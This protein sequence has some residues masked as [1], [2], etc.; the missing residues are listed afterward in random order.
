MIRLRKIDVMKMLGVKAH[1]FQQLLDDG[2]VDPPIEKKGR[3][4]YYTPAHVTRAR[5]R[6]DAITQAHL[7]AAAKS[8]VKFRPFRKSITDQID[9]AELRRRS[10][11]NQGKQW[12]VISESNDKKQ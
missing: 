4:P 5:E 7:T 11:L 12:M 1:T 9:V 3:R 10:E 6:Q 2:I 8:E